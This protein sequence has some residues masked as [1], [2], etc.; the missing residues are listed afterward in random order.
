[1]TVDDSADRH[2]GLETEV[3]VFC[4]P[5]PTTTGAVLIV[6]SRTRAHGVFLG[7]LRFRKFRT[8]KTDSNAAKMTLTRRRRPS[9]MIYSV[10]VP[11]VSNCKILSTLH[12]APRATTVPL[13]FLA[14]GIAVTSLHQNVSLKTSSCLAG[15]YAIRRFLT[16]VGA[17][18]R[19]RRRLST[20]FGKSRGN[21][22]K[23]RSK[24]GTRP[25]SPTLTTTSRT[26]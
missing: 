18:L 11:S 3:P 14:T 23:T 12:G 2:L 25:L 4:R 6:R 1:M 17:H 19:H 22:L 5:G 21:S 7:Y 20:L 26:D 13:V 16:T 10:V 15:P 24:T 8:L 9:L